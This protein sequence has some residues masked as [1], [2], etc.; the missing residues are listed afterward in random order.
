M[1][2]AIANSESVSFLVKL[3]AFEALTRAT[4]VDI[5]IRLIDA[6]PLSVSTEDYEDTSWFLTEEWQAK[7]READEDIRLGRYEG[8]NTVEELFAILDEQEEIAKSEE[9]ARR[10]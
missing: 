6:W 10:R 8:A 7:E 2:P 9:R 1:N 4:A 5:G 3:A